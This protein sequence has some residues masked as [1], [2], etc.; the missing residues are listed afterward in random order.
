MRDADFC[1]ERGA[2]ALDAAIRASRAAGL[3]LGRPGAPGAPDAI[4]TSREFRSVSMLE[5]VNT[6][7][8]QP[9]MLL[10]PW[11]CSRWLAQVH[12]WR[13]TGRL[14]SN[15]LYHRATRLV[16]LLWVTT[17]EG[18]GMAVQDSRKLTQCGPIRDVQ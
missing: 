12:A 14:P 4:L 6:P 13:G 1:V 17:I 5:L 3:Q 11:L 9:D 8:P 16:D 18:L 10:A 2:D 7:L 15:S